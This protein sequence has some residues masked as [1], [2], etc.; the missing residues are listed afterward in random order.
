MLRFPAVTI[1]QMREVDRIMVEEI[2]I[3]IL[4]MM[5]NASRNI[6][7]FSR[8]MLGGNVKN[9]K[10]LILCGKGNNG[11]DGL[12]AAR[13]LINFGA[14]PILFLATKPEALGNDSIIQYNILKNTQASIYTYDTPDKELLKDLLCHADLIIDALL[15]YSLKGNP[16]PPIDTMIEDANQSGMPIL[17]VDIPSGLDGNTG[18]A[19][20]STIKASTTLTLALPK[21]GLTQD[22]AKHYVGELYLADLSV[23]STIYKKLGINIP[24]MFEHEEIVK[25]F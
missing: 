16:R 19:A 5:E 25:V 10:I 3:S 6:A 11:G 24:D 8:T 1:D 9:K 7:V 18:I 13:H 12:G 14:T 15:G 2:G 17:S 20:D 4:M 22:A 21:V 23:P